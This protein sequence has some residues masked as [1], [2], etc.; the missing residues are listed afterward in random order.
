LLTVLSQSMRAAV[1]RGKDDVRVESISVPHIGEGEVLVR[2]AACGV[3]GTDLKKIHYGLVAP[4]R[5][6]GHETAGTIAAVGDGVGEWRVGDRVV[7]NH[8]VPCLSPDCFFCRRRAFSQCP[9]YKKTGTTAGF[10][11]AGGGFAEYVRVMD[12]C[13]DGGMVR[14]PDEV[15]FAEASFVEPLNTCLKGVRLADVQA[16]DTVLVVGQGPIGLLFTRLLT[17]AGANVVATDFYASRRELSCQFGASAALEPNANVADTIKTLSEGRGADLVVVAVPRTDVVAEAFALVRPA[18][19]I[20]L[21]AHT[22]LDDWMQVDAG[23]VCMQEKALIG[24]YSSDITLQ[25]ECAELIFA[26]QV[27]V[28]PLISHHL[29][30]TEIARAIDLAAHPTETSLKIVVEP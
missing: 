13:V 22:R 29:P 12:W 4:P 5:I 19:K 21:F 28:R 30:L 24:A 17:L 23:A 18:G 1:Y 14:I 26:R 7:V 10:E 15:T 8:H 3:C 27:D 11:P 20:L 6:F 2:V 16:G 9:T 25:D